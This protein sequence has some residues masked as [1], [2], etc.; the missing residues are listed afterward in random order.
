MLGEVQSSR[1]QG[2]AEKVIITMNDSANAS[3][4]AAAFVAAVTCND[5]NE[6]KR[7]L[8]EQN[9]DP[10]TPGPGALNLPIIA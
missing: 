6:A 7:L 9:V 10:D 4:S 3:S 5:A 1:A 2:T 8:Q